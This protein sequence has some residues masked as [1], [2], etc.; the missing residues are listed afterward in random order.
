MHRSVASPHLWCCLHACCR[1][2]RPPIRPPEI[3]IMHH[4]THR[5]SKTPHVR[6]W[7]VAAIATLS[8]ALLLSACGG[9]SNSSAAPT[10]RAVSVAVTDAPTADFD[11]VWITVKSIR[12]HKLHFSRPDDPNW[13]TYSL[14]Q[15]V[16]VELTQP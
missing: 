1:H 7:F 3:A 8:A 10:F 13:L 14:A 15:P 12:F 16:T 2:R 9:G 5:F 6:S 11:H 4:A